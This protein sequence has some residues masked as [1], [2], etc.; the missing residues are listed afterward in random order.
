MG[1][2]TFDLQQNEVRGELFDLAD[3]VVFKDLVWDVERVE[4]S[5]RRQWIK[6]KL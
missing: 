2:V 5:S 3:R 4:I 6:G 1:L